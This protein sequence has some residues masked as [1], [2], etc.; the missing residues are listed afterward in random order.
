MSNSPITS[1]TDTDELKALVVNAVT[2]AKALLG[3]LDKNPG[4]LTELKKEFKE[5]FGALA[6]GKLVKLIF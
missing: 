6:I 4:K 3:Y 5:R 2:A 1:D